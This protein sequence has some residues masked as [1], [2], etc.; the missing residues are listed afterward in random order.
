MET[1]EECSSSASRFPL[2]CLAS[3]ALFPLLIP[4][5]HQSPIGIV[6]GD[7][8][9]VHPKRNSRDIKN[10]SEREFWADAQG[11]GGRLSPLICDILHFRYWDI[12]NI[13]IFEATRA[14]SCWVLAILLHVIGL[15][16][17][18]KESTQGKVLAPGNV[19]DSSAPSSIDS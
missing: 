17:Q 19:Y 10:W 8:E 3:C 16:T 1:H 14:L 2:N 13:K 9:A 11:V 5:L 12:S 6:P 15:E 4:Q 7:Q 18:A